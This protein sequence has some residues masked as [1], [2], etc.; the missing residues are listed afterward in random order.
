MNMTVINVITISKFIPVL[1]QHIINVSFLQ[2]VENMNVE[3][4]NMNVEGHFEGPPDNIEVK[5]HL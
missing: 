5:L 1:N 4:E 3:M 2:E